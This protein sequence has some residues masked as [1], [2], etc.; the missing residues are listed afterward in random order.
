MSCDRHRNQRGTTL[1]EA[2]VAVGLFA[3]GAATMSKL[4]AEQMRMQVTNGTATT[5]IALAEQELE[6][7]RAL[8]YAEIASRSAEA[9][10]GRITYKR[11]TIVQN[12][13]PGPNMKTV[14]ATVRWNEPLGEKTYSLYA[15]YT[16][17]SR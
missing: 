2:V 7:I 5:A 9:V 10:V 15:I 14:T 17:V 12:D 1:I 8:D 13:R 4:M 11:D 6:D 3:I 16:A